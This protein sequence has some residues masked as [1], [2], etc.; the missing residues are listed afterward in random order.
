MIPFSAG[1]LVGA[2]GAPVPADS[3]GPG[4]GAGFVQ[5]ERI[6]RD[7]TADFEGS[8][9]TDRNGTD[10]T[11]TRTRIEL[12]NE[13]R[14]LRA[15]A[16]ADVGTLRV[17]WAPIGRIVARVEVPYAW[18]EPRGASSDR[19]LGDVR[20]LLGWN[21]FR[22]P[23]FSMFFGAGLVF[24]TADEDSLGQGKNQIVPTVAAAGA[25]PEIHSKLFETFT[26]AVSYGGSSS[27]RG[28]QLSRLDI[29]LMTDWPNAFW[30]ELGTTVT[31]D[32]VGADKDGLG[33]AAEVGKMLNPNVGLWLR[34]GVGGIGNDTS[35]PNW[36]FEVGV[37][38]LF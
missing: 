33:F 20:T 38:W 37:R 34:P 14:A 12:R 23:N 5:G 8:L 11:W 16:R 4:L 25:I 10:P 3:F 7:V 29:D 22:D 6:H 13:W 35:V 27:R 36:S 30:T 15:G 28:V 32:S 2:L 9:L 1:L 19:G 21:S 26:H 17:D 31:V 24:D 18:L